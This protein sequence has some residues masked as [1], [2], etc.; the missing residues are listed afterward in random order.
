VILIIGVSALKAMAPLIIS[1]VRDPVKRNKDVPIKGFI[2]SLLL[3][4]E[5]ES[6][7]AILKTTAFASSATATTD[8]LSS[9]NINNFIFFVAVLSLRISINHTLRRFRIGKNQ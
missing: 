3:A 8:L 5:L 9:D 6:A 4:L 7:N 2:N 1:I